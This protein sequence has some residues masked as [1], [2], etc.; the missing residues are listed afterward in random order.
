MRMKGQESMVG[1]TVKSYFSSLRELWHQALLAGPPL[2]PAWREDE[3]HVNC[4]KRSSRDERV[5]TTR[6]LFTGLHQGVASLAFQYGRL[7]TMYNKDSI[8]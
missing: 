5:R 2:K 8:A 6:R 7:N 3:G 4:S 1:S